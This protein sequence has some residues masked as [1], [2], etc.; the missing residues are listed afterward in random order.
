MSRRGWALFV[1]MSVIWDVPYLL[2]KVAVE[3]LAP[4]SLVFL[5]CAIAATLLGPRALARGHVRPV[6]RRSRPLLLFTALEMT[7]PWLLLAYAEQT[8]SSSLT[9][10]LVASVPMVAVL[11][12]RL[13]GGADR[14]DGVRLLGLCLGMVGVAALL[15]PALGS[16]DLLAVGAV[17]L[18]VLGYATGPLVVTKALDGVSSTGVNTVALTVTALVYLPFAAPSLAGDPLPSRPVVVSVVLPSRLC[19][20]ATLLLF[21]A[22]IREAGPNRALAITVVNPAVAVALGIVALGEPLTAGMVVSFSLV[23]TGAGARH[24]PQPVG[25]GR[26]RGRR[27]DL[28]V[29]SGLAVA[30]EEADDDAEDAQGEVDEVVEHDLV[31][32]RHQPEQH[33]L[34]ERHQ[35]DHQVGDPD[36]TDDRAGD[37]QVAREPGVEQQPAGEQVDAVLGD[38]DVEDA[39]QGLLTEDQSDQSDEDDARPDHLGVEPHHVGHRCASGVRTRAKTAPVA[40]AW[41]YLS[42]RSTAQSFLLQ[43]PGS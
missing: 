21:F 35:T 25:R 15:G 5:C 22:L 9:G 41:T 1:A 23:L 43:V 28:A 36:P 30:D 16:G 33:G 4:V 6:L 40:A 26:R 3:G 8:L 42:T 17:A 11:A 18:V 29:G 39:E 19:T 12:G 31:A 38:V 37:P 32:G 27:A 13:A 7:G 10:L 14:L 34:G 24:A 20:V 2:I